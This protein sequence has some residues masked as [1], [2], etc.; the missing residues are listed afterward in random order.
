VKDA[1][2]AAVAIEVSRD[3]ELVQERGRIAD[4]RLGGADGALAVG[5]LQPALQRGR[6]VAGGDR[7]VHE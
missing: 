4:P 5:V 2:E 6:L 7:R 3:D 1:A